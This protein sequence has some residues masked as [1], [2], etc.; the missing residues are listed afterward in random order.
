MFENEFVTGY[1]QRSLTKTPDGQGGYT[2]ANVDVTFSG[3]IK[4]MGASEK[5]VN[6]RRGLTVTHRIYTEVGLSLSEDDLILFESNVYD[7]IYWNDVM[8][9]GELLQIDVALR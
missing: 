1:T 7:V 2:T 5:T 3:A 4:M 6:S 8:R 9:E